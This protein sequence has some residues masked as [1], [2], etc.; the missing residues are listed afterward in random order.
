VQKPIFVL[1]QIRTFL[2]DCFAQIA[3][4]LQ[5]IFL[6]YCS[7]LWQELMMQHAP[8]IKENCKQNLHI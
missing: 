1:P 6:I 4:N 7:T 5:V 8:A 2:A 3:Y